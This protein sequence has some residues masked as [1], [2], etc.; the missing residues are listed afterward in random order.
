MNRG[1]Y[2]DSCAVSTLKMIV[3][4]ST[5]I[6]VRFGEC[7]WRNFPKSWF[8]EEVDW[9]LDFWKNS[10]NLIKFLCFHW[11]NCNS[12]KQS[13][14]FSSLTSFPFWV[15]PQKP[16]KNSQRMSKKSR[17][18]STRPLS[19]R[20]TKLLSRRTPYSSD[21]FR[22]DSENWDSGRKTPWQEMR[23]SSV[24]SSISWPTSSSRDCSKTESF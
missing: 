3:L 21:S 2:T 6:S 13:C 7:P 8:F 24:T 19:H 11:S 17:L 10:G 22:E 20:I 14:Y 18:T 16:S 23:S 5:L 4:N 9:L 15:G 12:W 1:T